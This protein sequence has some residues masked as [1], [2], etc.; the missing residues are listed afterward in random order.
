MKLQKGFSAVLILFIALIVIISGGIF[1]MWHHGSSKMASSDATSVV[2]ST[3]ITTSSNP[4][5]AGDQQSKN[6]RDAQR[7][8]DMDTLKALMDLYMADVAPSKLTCTAKTIYAS[9]SI[10]PPSGWKAGLNMGSL[11]VNGTGWIP[12]NFT[13][14]SS[15]SPLEM[16]PVDPVNNSINHLVYLFACDPINQTYEIDTILE[17]QKSNKGGAYDL[18]TTDGGNDPKVFEIG[19]D[20]TLIPDNFWR[21]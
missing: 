17:G 3:T 9:A 2:S 10:T 19:T 15:G 1:V 6:E 8:S 12:I 14:I 4:T 21:Q 16:L 20:K 13:A 5:I 11:S 7:I 18:A